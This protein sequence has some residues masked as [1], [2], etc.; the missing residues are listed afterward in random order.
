[1]AG[2]GRRSDVLRSPKYLR[3]AIPGL[4]LVL[5]SGAF[6]RQDWWAYVALFV[7]LGLIIVPLPTTPR[8]RDVGPEEPPGN[9]TGA[10]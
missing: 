8:D 4:A 5:L 1:M 10:R 7:G 2:R 3:L 6:W 9:W